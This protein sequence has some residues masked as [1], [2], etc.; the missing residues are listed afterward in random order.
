MN[1]YRNGKKKQISDEKEIQNITIKIN[2]V[3]SIN[4]DCFLNHDDLLPFKENRL[5][6]NYLKVSFVHN[7]IKEPLNVSF[8]SNLKLI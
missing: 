6:V 1:F 2:K 3:M 4:V 5:I 8:N 7:Q